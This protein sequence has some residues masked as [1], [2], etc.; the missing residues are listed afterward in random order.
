M[1][2]EAHQLEDVVTQYFGLS[3]SNYRLE[4][5]ARDV[6][7]LAASK[8]LT[9]RKAR[10]DI[11]RAADRVRDRARAFFSE[12]AFGHR[13]GD[14]PKNEER[15]RVTDSSLAGARDQ[16]AALTGAL[17]VFEATF[18]LLG[19]PAGAGRRRRRPA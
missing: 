15:I 10:D 3:V 5:L 13:S 1:L 14:R 19:T 8:T 7:R 4:D 11:A 18:A 9:D 17:D 16:G 2:D 12:V 6:E